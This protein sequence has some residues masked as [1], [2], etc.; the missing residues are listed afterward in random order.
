MT[1]TG[2]IEKSLSR[3]DVHNEQCLHAHK[4]FGAAAST[5]DQYSEVQEKVADTVA[6][7][8]RRFQ[9]RHILEAG[10]GTGLL[11]RRILRDFESAA[12]TAVDASPSMVEQSRKRLNASSSRVSWQVT[13]LAGMNLPCRYD[14]ACSSSVLHWVQPWTK[15]F[16]SISRALLPEG[17]LVAGI[18]LQGTLHELS[19]ARQCAAPEKPN[20]VHLPSYDDIQH[21]C[22]SAGLKLDETDTQR[23][24]ARYTSV[25]E[26]L[27]ALHKQGVTGTTNPARRPLNRTE[28]NRLVL[29]YDQ[30]F[31]QSDGYLPATFQVLFL[32]ATK[33]FHHA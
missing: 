22:S 31:R 12:V 18:M 14:L 7:M 6:S 28:L 4:R 15:A 19:V 9:P 25:R 10:C 20:A 27:A 5:Y 8:C 21:A 1:D 3:N 23:I 33:R 2:N 11:T 32:Q 29:E 16:R 17:V 24:V 13:D 26:F 30:R